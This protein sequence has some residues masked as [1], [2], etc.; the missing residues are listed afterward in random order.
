MQ[1]YLLDSIK[2]TEQIIADR[3]AELATEPDEFIKGVLQD[4]ID[5]WERC[6]ATDKK[7]LEKLRSK[8]SEK[9]VQEQQE[10]CI[11]REEKKMKTDSLTVKITVK[12]DE[13]LNDFIKAVN[14]LK[15]ITNRLSS[16]QVTME[17][18]AGTEAE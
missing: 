17:T 5:A 4:T 7:I 1:Q 16:L 15:E 11:L 14:D 10:E 8:E 6:L 2:K 9:K 3:K 12:E 18:K 13:V